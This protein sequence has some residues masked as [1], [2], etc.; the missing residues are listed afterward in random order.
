MSILPLE[1]GAKYSKKEL[2]E[3][4]K[5]SSLSTVREGIYYCK[6]TPTSLLFCDLEKQGKEKRFHF[7]DFF[8]GEYFHW[9]SQT[10]QHINSPKVQEIISGKRMP[11]LFARI[12]PKIKSK[13]QPF[14]YCGRLVY[15]EHDKTTAK[16]VHMVMRNLDYDDYT[17]NEELLDIYLW[18]PEGRGLETSYKERKKYGQ[19]PARKTKY[20]KPNRTERQG[21]VTSRVG[22]GFHR[23]EILEKWGGKCAATGCGIK[24]ILISSHIVPWS[25]SSD[26]ERLDIENGILLSPNVDALFDRHLISFDDEGFLVISERIGEEILETLGVDIESRI[27]V[28]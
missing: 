11:H 8:Q 7:N 4:L 27:S 17:D 12:T 3:I 25:E 6:N 26:E 14:I 21:L 5:E 2:A 24:S 28:T 10:T 9:D 16:P 15:H 20:R 22:Q 18:K 1:I 19:S 23:Q 13:T